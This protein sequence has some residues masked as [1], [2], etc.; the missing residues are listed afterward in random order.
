M[1]FFESTTIQDP[2]LVEGTS[3]KQGKSK[4]GRT[5]TL[6]RSRITEVLKGDALTDHTT[7]MEYPIKKHK[8][9]IL[10]NYA[11]SYTCKGSTHGPSGLNGVGKLII[12]K[13]S[14]GPIV[15]IKGSPI[16]DGK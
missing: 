7:I 2:K 3:K 8:N 14:P 11:L 15:F 16:T 12:T 13:T 1:L 5:Q 10:A 4:D 9:P 6:G